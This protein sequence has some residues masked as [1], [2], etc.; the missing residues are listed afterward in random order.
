LQQALIGLFRLRRQLV[1]APHTRLIYAIRR[2]VVDRSQAHRRRDFADCLDAGRGLNSTR[3]CHT[4]R[5]ILR[6]LVFRKSISLRRHPQSS[7]HKP[8]PLKKSGLT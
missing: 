2:L 5:S 8:L 4:S 3:S 1:V 7:F 6:P